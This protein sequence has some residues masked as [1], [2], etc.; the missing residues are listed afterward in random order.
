MSVQRL[1]DRKLF[2][3]VG[4]INERKWLDDGRRKC[5]RDSTNAVADGK[6]LL[7]GSK[8]GSGKVVIRR[9][10]REQSA[11]EGLSRFCLLLEEIFEALISQGLVD[12][13]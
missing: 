13:V 10:P 3:L 6:S 1:Q 5:H 12:E 2:T 11:E 8:R 7:M 4:R 9:D